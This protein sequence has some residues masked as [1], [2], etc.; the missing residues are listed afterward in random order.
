MSYIPGI[1]CGAFLVIRNTDF[2]D[3][4]VLDMERVRLLSVVSGSRASQKSTVYDTVP[5]CL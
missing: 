1:S 5:A 2:M 4:L 3:S